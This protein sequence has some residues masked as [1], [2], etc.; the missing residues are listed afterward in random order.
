VVHREEDIDASPLDAASADV[1]LLAEGC[2]VAE[3]WLDDLRAAAYSDSR[4]A[5]ATALSAD[6][7]TGVQLPPGMSF[8]EAAQRVQ[9]ASLRIHPRVTEGAAYCTYIRRSALELVGEFRDI[10]TF[11]DQCLRLGLCHVVADGVLVRPTKGTAAPT[12]PPPRSPL[13]RALGAARRALRGLSIVVDGRILSGPMNGTKLHALELIAAVARSSG[14][15]VQVFVNQDLGADTRALLETVR[16]VEPVAL[17][18]GRAHTLPADVV[19]RPFQIES[20]ADLNVLASFGD[21][22]VITQQDLISYHNPS[23]FP[24]EEGWRGYR[25]LTRRAMAVADHVV[26]FTA[27]ARDEALAEELVEPDRASVVHIGVDH[28]VTRSTSSEPAQP[29]GAERIAPEAEVILCV[30]TDYRHKNRPFA[31]RVLEQLRRAHGWQGWLVFAGSKVA[32]GGSSAEEADL[33]AQHPGLDRAVV[34]LGEVSEPEKEWLLRRASLVLYPT[35]YEGFGLVPFEAAEHGVP[36][37]WAQG[38]SLS[39]LLPDSAAAIVPWDR[40]LSADHVLELMRDERAATSNIE[41]V[42]EAASHLRWEAAGVHLVQL[43]RAACDAPPALAGLLERGEGLMR[44]GLS[45]D[46]MRLVG[47]NGALPPD[48]ERPLLALATHPTLR[49]PV[50]GA[51]RAAYRTSQRWRGKPNGR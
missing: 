40:V 19:H 21:R 9:R 33:L 49:V 32:F 38:S 29:K 6:A 4:I 24:S 18:S 12:E 39:E 25:E 10:R 44:A 23:Y 26:F 43:Y 5:T 3:G 51:I 16:G 46:A 30:G 27:H 31:L 2:E 47:P 14:H 50:F 37:M 41:A 11:S 7:L 22:L 15:S 45:E 42:R 1:V 48:L 8:E 17:S 35:V 36:C 28:T 34:D 20:P 13:H